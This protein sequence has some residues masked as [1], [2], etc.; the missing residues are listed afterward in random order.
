WFKTRGTPIRDSAGRVVKWFGTCTDISDLRRMDTE[1]R[2]AKEGEAERARLAELGRDVGIAL[3]RGDTLHQLLQPCA[4][5]VV[6]YLDAAFARIWWLPP[7]KEIL[8][9]QASAGM[10]THL[11]GPHAHVRLGQ[12]KIGQIAQERQPVLTNEVRTDPRIQDSS[13]AQ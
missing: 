8:E 11:D 5:A 1:L 6:H 12:F 9:L 4:E 3:N 2:Q 13:W 10:Y 7:G